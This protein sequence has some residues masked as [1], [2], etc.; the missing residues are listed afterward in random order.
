V[1]D[2]TDWGIGATNTGGSQIFKGLHIYPR[3]S[4]STHFASADALVSNTAALPSDAT[5]RW[6]SEV[7]FATYTGGSYQR[8]VEFVWGLNQANIGGGINSI[9]F[10][11]G[12]NDQNST[13]GADGLAG[14]YGI[15]FSPAI[16][17]ADNLILEL[18]TRTTWARKAL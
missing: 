14:R 16:P 18:A 8:D 2:A 6:A 1:N 17:K 10:D 12:Q 7:N 3:A 5:S 15:G 4:F 13:S 9:Y 11:M